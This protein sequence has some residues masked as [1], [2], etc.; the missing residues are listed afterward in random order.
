MNENI[1]N[2]L[3][4]IGLTQREAEVYIALLKMGKSSVLDISKNVKIHR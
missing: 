4:D 3:K 1:L 2:L